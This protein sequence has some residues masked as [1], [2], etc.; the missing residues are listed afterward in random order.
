VDGL[1]WAV[2]YDAGTPVDAEPVVQVTG[3]LV[4]AAQGATAP[5]GL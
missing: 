2:R 4:N 5:P 3:E 1:S